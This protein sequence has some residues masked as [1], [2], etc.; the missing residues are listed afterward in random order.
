[1][2]Q[3][4]A[5]FIL[6]LAFLQTPTFKSDPPHKCDD[7]DAWNKPREPFKLFGNSYYVGTD[8]LSAILI[9]GD[10]GLILLDGGLE[11]SA[12]VID[13]NIRKLGFKTEDVKLIV[14]SHGHYDHAGGIAALQRASGAT[15]A[16]SPAGASA[17]QRGENTPDDPQY[18]FGRAANAYPPVKNVKIIKD[19]EVLRV[20][21]LA[22]TAVFMPG[23]TP[24]STTWTWRSCEGK[25]CYD[26]VYADSVSAVVAPGFKYT[27]E[28]ERVNLFRR[29]ISR[30]AEMPCD[31]V[32]STHPQAT[33]LDGKLKKRAELKGAGPDPFVDHGCKALAANALKGLEARIAEEK[34]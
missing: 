29:S 21:N 15:V 31:I 6:L 3:F 14:N 5:A 34:K 10:N 30:L 13:A 18:G 24:G 27:A 7:C 20:G 12:A 22:I 9:A 8:G 1:M 26:M 33:N 16:A 17:L 23:H 19:N 4:A 11:Q 25:T 2:S 28:P 32:V